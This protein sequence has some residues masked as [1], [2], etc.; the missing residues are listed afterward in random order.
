MTS[1]KCGNCGYQFEAKEPYEKCPSC[2]KECEFID[3]T[4]YVPKMDRSGRVCKCKVC[5]TEVK[6]INDGGG[7]IK[8]CDELMVLE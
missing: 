1:W 3:V 2:D 6:V 5:G 4:N 7:F 8:C